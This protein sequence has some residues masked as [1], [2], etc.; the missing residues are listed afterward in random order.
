MMFVTLV[1]ADLLAFSRGLP[2][3]RLEF[4][5]VRAAIAFAVPSFLKKAAAYLSPLSRLP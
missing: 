1:R 4:V 2:V 5:M 3:R